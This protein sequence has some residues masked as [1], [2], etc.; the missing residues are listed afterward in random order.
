MLILSCQVW[1]AGQ[2]V[3]LIHDIP[4]CKDLVSR[5]E[6]E[7]IESLQKASSLIVDEQPP[8]DVRGKPASEITAKL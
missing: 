4:S 2:V 3:G 6:K 7:A 8:A 5:I 1:T